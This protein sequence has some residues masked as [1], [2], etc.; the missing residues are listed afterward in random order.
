MP[1]SDQFPASPK[2]TAGALFVGFL[3]V[4]LS[5]F[6]GV[7]PF[8]RRMLVEQRRW[9]TE[10]EFTGILSLSQFLPGPNIVNVSIIVGRRFQGPLGALAAT[11]GLLLMPLI[12]V[13]L[14]ATVYAEYAQIEAVRG[15]TSGVSAAASGLVLAVAL[16]MARP[17]RHTLWQIGIAAAAFVAIG[18]ARL[19]LLWVLA[20][21]APLSL[22]IAWR[23]R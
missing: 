8:A 3:K 21:L 6:G 14:L 16:K 7:L 10:E 2:V 5:G 22:A 20:V 17:I 9:L 11:V 23:R 12:I 19:P 15:A 4:G 13:V 1:V 18:F